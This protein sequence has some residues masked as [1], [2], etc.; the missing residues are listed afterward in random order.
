M[1]EPKGFTFPRTS[2]GRSSLVPSPPWHY[3]GDMLTIEYRTD[4]AAVAELLPAPL[5]PAEDDPAPVPILP[6]DRPSCSDPL[7]RVR[8]PARRRRQRHCRYRDRSKGPPH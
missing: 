2:S 1:A 7:H 5:P 4:P 8:A 3:S 6:A